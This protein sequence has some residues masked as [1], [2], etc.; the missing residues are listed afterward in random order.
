NTFVA[1]FL[2]NPPM[3]LLPAVVTDAPGGRTLAVGDCR[4]QVPAERMPE[5][6]PGTELTFGIRPENVSL[7]ARAGDDMARVAG[8]VIQVEA[9]GA[10]SVVTAAL[11]QVSAS[12]TA[13]VAGD[14]G[15]AVGHSCDLYLDLA[16]ARVFGADGEAL[17]PSNSDGAN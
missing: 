2:G 11:P 9:L 10:E 14:P 17:I 12:L 8:Q 16:T 1:G 4:L 15:F 7:G 3:N 6:A 5:R 13:R